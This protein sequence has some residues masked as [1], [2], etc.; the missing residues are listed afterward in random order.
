[1]IATVVI[2]EVEGVKPPTE[3]GFPVYARAYGVHGSS[4]WKVD[5]GLSFKVPK[6]YS[7]RLE[8]F[9]RFIVTGWTFVKG[10]L[11]VLVD[12]VEGGFGPKEE[13]VATAWFERSERVAVRFVERPREGGRLIRGDAKV[14]D[15]AESGDAESGE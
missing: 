12:L 1:M 3:N 10:R 6:G 9:G 14:V 8:S 2:E 7:F 4:P 15:C 13:Q 11:I 5:S